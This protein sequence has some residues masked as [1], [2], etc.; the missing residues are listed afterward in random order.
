MGLVGAVVMFVVYWFIALFLILPRGQA[1]QLEDGSVVPG[2]PGG[3]PA[4]LNLGRKFLWA[5]LAALIGVALSAG[6][7]AS[8]WVE[9]RD[10]SFLFP[11]SF[12]EPTA[13][14]DPGE[15]AR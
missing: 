1:T 15:A 10:F 9:L 6:L 7:I 5:T 4:D 3:A 12:H 2:T 14:A 11:E 8:G 13:G